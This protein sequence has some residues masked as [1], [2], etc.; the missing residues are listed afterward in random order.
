MCGIG[1]SES[2][3]AEHHS[4]APERHGMSVCHNP[5]A[6]NP[7]PVEFLDGFSSRHGFEAGHYKNQFREFT[8]YSSLTILY[9]TNGYA[10]R[11][12]QLDERLRCEAAEK[13]QEYAVMI[14]GEAEFVVWR[15]RFIS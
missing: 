3:S 9:S 10:D 11:L 7:I 14:H 6:L 5:N 1:E 2:Q 4:Q 8:P 12:A 13:A 15:D